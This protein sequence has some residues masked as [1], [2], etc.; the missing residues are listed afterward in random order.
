MLE[1]SRE[2]ALLPSTFEG[3]LVVLLGFLFSD[4]TKVG[5][6]KYSIAVFPVTWFHEQKG[7]M[8]KVRTLDERYFGKEDKKAPT[9][10]K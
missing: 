8:E 6:K 5:S 3:L 1:K 2:S 4:T 9:N 7:M 10:R